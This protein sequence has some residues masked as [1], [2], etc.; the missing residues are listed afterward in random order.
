MRAEGQSQ[1]KE[2]F[3]LRE[4]IKQAMQAESGPSQAASANHFSN[5]LETQ[6]QELCK[7]RRLVEEHQRRERCCQR[8][9]NALLK[10]NLQ[11]QQRINGDNQ[12]LIRQRD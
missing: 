5:I 12:Q 10:E 11:L 4:G 2:L 7:L 1:Q 3:Q 6:S 9:W 8:K